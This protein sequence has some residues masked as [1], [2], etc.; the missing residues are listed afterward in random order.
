MRNKISRR[1]F[2]EKLALGTGALTLS[3]RLIKSNF[4]QQTEQK[5]N[6]K[7][8]IALMGLGYYSTDLLAPALQLTKNIRLAGIVTGTPAKEK[9]WAE[10][11]NIPANNI[12]NYKNFDT[13]S[14]NPEI[15]IVYVVLPNDMHKEFTIRAARAGKHVICEKPMALNV[16]E[17]AEMV[18]ACTANSVRLSLGYRLH[19]DPAT[20]HIIKLRNT[21]KLGKVDYVSASSGFRNKSPKSAWRL[22]K[23]H[24]GGVLMDMGVYSIQAARYTVGEE[25]FA[26]TAQEYKSDPQR[27]DEV[28]EIVTIQMEFPGGAIADLM[29]TF[30]ST[31]NMLYATLQKGWFQLSPFW[32]YSG[33]EGKSSLGPIPK[34]NVNQQAAHM[35]SVAWCIE[36]NQPMVT[37]AE[38]GISD[39]KI[40]MAVYQALESGKKVKIG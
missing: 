32:S 18:K 10:K 20:Q 6:K 17:C 8:G 14:D 3:P 34:S 13:I 16:A 40:I 1:D 38:E 25:P 4:D 33:L 19:Y 29:T 35:D 36:N 9:S 15:D 37:G 22:Q 2:V 31:P 7:Y 23:K 28:D 26:L 12:Y 24:G 11:Y 21:D 5:T 30:H 39:M 27:F